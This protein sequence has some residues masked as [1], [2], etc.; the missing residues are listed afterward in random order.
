[1][2]EYV[3]ASQAVA[4]LLSLSWRSYEQRR[5]GPALRADFSDSV[6]RHFDVT[7]RTPQALVL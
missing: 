1:M 5:K 3:A 7:S 4:R 6:F 2:T